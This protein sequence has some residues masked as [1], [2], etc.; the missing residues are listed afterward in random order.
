MKLKLREMTTK[1]STRCLKLTCPT[2]LIIRLKAD[3]AAAKMIVTV[4]TTTAVMMT[5]TVAVITSRITKD[6]AA[7]FKNDY[8]IT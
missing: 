5:V 3:V 2:V 7:K 4:M 1:A 6:A 8:S